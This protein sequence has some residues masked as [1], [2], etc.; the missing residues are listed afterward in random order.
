MSRQASGFP[1]QYCDP[2]RTVLKSLPFIDHERRVE[3]A[4]TWDSVKPARKIHGFLRWYTRHDR[5]VIFLLRGFVTVLPLILSRLNVGIEG[6]VPA[7]I[8]GLYVTE[9]LARQRESLKQARWMEE[10]YDVHKQMRRQEHDTN[11]LI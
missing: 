8:I 5:K 2:V 9:T 10:A 6:I 3:L 11:P 4:R 7:V 1:H